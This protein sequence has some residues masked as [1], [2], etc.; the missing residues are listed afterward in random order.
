MEDTDA[1]ELDAAAVRRVALERALHVAPVPELEGDPG[2][3]AVH[4]QHLDG[5][6]LGGRREER[7]HARLQ[8]L[9]IRVVDAVL[10]RQR[11]RQERVVAAHGRHLLPRQRLQPCKQ[12]E[13][14]CFV[15]V[16]FLGRSID[17]TMC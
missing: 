17:C 5:E 14:F 4:V 10:R 11:G 2:R 16:I 7:G 15:S 8:R 12:Q 13:K 6:A 9:R 3:A 1:K